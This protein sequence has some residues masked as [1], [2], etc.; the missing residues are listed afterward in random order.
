MKKRCSSSKRRIR[1]TFLYRIHIRNF[2]TFCSDPILL[3][4]ANVTAIWNIDSGNLFFIFS[5]LFSAPVEANPN[6]S[7]INFLFHF[8]FHCKLPNGKTVSTNKVCNNVIFIVDQTNQK[9]KKGWRTATFVP[10][11]IVSVA[12]N[13][14][15]YDKH[16]ILLILNVSYTKFQTERL[17]K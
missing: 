4:F 2:A 14:L 1:N 10:Y 9:Q 12:S 15:E 11:F 7:H 16:F 8:N 17:K 3:Q 13:F 6:S 5:P